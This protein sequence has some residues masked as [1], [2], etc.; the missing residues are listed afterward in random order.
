MLQQ[1][2]QIGFGK[3]SRAQGALRFVVP[4]H[5]LA[6]AFLV[7]ALQNMASIKK[8][9]SIPTCKCQGALPGAK[10]HFE[11]FSIC[12]SNASVQ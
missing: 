9:L 11:G 10:S 3:F 5:R 4:T 12:G 2:N 8:Q 6:N 7:I 1:I